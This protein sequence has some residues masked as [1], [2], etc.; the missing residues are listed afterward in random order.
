MDAITNTKA[1]DLTR[2]ALTQKGV[3]AELAKSQALRKTRK[4]MRNLLKNA[5]VGTRR[6]CEA[7]T[8][9]YFYLVERERILLNA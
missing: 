9:K 8:R 5:A 1:A 3:L 4:R 6:V 7:R 2:F